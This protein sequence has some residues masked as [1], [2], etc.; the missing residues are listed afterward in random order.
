MIQ[1]LEAEIKEMKDQIEMIRSET[2]LKKHLIEVHR[3]K[4]KEAAALEASSKLTSKST[5]KNTSMK[6]PIGTFRYQT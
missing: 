4:T 3:S 2:E 5:L 6:P 1:F